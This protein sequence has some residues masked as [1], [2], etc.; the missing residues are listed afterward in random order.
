MVY[1]WMDIIP[2]IIGPFLGGGI[3]WIVAFKSQKRKVGGE[4]RQIEATAQSTEIGN[5]SKVADE[6]QDLSVNY[7]TE[8][9][10]L[11]TQFTE[12]KETFAKMK[13]SIMYLIREMDCTNYK[14]I[15]DKIIDEV[16]K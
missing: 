14:E 12:L 7:K 3:V 10:S 4:V 1:S 5:V 6:W 16:L 2:S 8:L 9:L 13:I 11:Q 15:G